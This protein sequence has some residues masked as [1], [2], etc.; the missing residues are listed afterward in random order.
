MA[1][2]IN[3]QPSSDTAGPSWSSE[4]PE[5]SACFPENVTSPPIRPLLAMIEF[6]N[7]KMGDLQTKVENLN[8][9]VNVLEAT[10]RGV[11]E[12]KKSYILQN[13]T[14]LETPI[15]E[16]QSTREPIH[17]MRYHLRI[18]GNI[19]KRIYT[20]SIVRGQDGKLLKVAIYE[21]GE[22]IISGPLAFAEFEVLILE[23]NFNTNDQESWTSEKFEE[24]LV[25]FR[26]EVGPIL[27]HDYRLNFSNG[28]AVLDG[29][30]FKDNSSWAVEK[31]WRL[32]IRVLGSFNLRVREAISDP[33]RVLDRHGKATEKPDTPLLE[34]RVDRLHKVG[35][36]RAF[37]LTENNINTVKDFLQL[38]HKS[39][40]RLLKILGIKSEFD[41]SWKTMVKHAKKCN[42]GSD[43][44]SY[45]KKNTVIFFNC[46]Y[47]VV[48]AKFRNRYRPFDKLRDSKKILVNK[49]KKGFYKDIIVK[50]FAADFKILN[51][52]PVP[53]DYNFT[54]NSVDDEAPQHEPDIQNDANQNIMSDHNKTQDYSS[55]PDET[56]NQVHGHEGSFVTP[57][58]SLELN[59]TAV[60]ENLIDSVEESSKD[61]SFWEEFLQTEHAYEDMP[62]PSIVSSP[63]YAASDTFDLC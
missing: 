55:I 47:E 36:K 11:L 13:R 58:S 23:G 9:R 14:I 16:N 37:I 3:F 49:L 60:N 56:V 7:C 6:I 28:E 39:Q 24:S 15:G 57:N 2:K 44:Y 35:T 5:L 34:D 48:G 27:A 19:N 38:Y 1:P 25:K 26:K 31:K 51:G 8:T 12:G 18:I 17:H 46:A 61:V 41:E 30:I 32:G 42:V 59:M 22:K 29:L 21:N 50:P 4:G 53:V 54:G 20:G 52:Q 45:R 40:T 43:L 10:V 63:I 33:F 62:M